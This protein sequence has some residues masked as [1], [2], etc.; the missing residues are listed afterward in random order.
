M[1]R[2]FF[3]NVYKNYDLF[4]A[5]KTNIAIFLFLLMTVHV[6][7]MLKLYMLKAVLDLAALF[8]LTVVSWVKEASIGN[9][10]V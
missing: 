2:Y 7:S 10:D 5:Y 3:K 4:L 8:V 6:E 1:L 9:W